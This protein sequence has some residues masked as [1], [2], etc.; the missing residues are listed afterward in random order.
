MV[1]STPREALAKRLIEIS[2]EDNL[3]TRMAVE[4]QISNYTPGEIIQ[5]L[6]RKKPAYYEKS[7]LPVYLP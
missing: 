4:E 3:I 7:T 5:I 2:A 1:S 6:L